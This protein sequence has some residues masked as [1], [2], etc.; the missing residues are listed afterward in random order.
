[1]DE[2]VLFRT[3]SREIYSA[4][5]MKNIEKVIRAF[6]NYLRDCRRCEL[7][8]SD[9]VGYVL[10]PIN[11]EKSAPPTGPWV[12]QGA[13]DLVSAL[14]REISKDVAGTEKEKHLSRKEQTEF[15]RRIRDYMTQL[16]EYQ[17]CVPKGLR[18]AVNNWAHLAH[19]F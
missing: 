7:L 13:G 12:I 5:E 18:Y 15:Q 16:P 1:M 19:L 11:R 2:K 9:K 6:Y 14:L 10:I 3:E 4:A 8:W 17:D